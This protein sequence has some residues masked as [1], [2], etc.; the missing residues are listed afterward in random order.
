MEMKNAVAQDQP[1]S[2]TSMVSESSDGSVF[3]CLAL[4]YGNYWQQ[5]HWP[6]VTGNSA[7]LSTSQWSFAPGTEGTPAPSVD[8]WP[9]NASK[10]I[11]SY[12]VTEDGDEMW[13]FV[14]SVG[15]IGLAE[16]LFAAETVVVV[17]A[18]GLA[19]T[20]TTAV[21]AGITLSPVIIIG[22]PLTGLLILCVL[23]SSMPD[24]PKLAYYNDLA[25]QSIEAQA[26]K[27][28]RVDSSDEHSPYVSGTFANLATNA[29]IDRFARA[30]ANV[31][32]GGSS[33]GGWDGEPPVCGAYVDAN[34]VVRRVWWWI[35]TLTRDYQDIGVMIWAYVYNGMP[36]NFGGAFD[37]KYKNA[38]PKIPPDLANRGWRVK[39]Y[40]SCSEAEFEPGEF[41][42]PPR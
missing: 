4:M 42:S 3:I 7:D 40:N 22:A 39:I 1:C 16:S 21:A 26:M 9:T 15:A 35:H 17:E 14:P 13:S 31:A 11:Y 24:D 33:N 34:G 30:K 29:L 18:T 20:E 41:N 25:R 12:F 38:L 32:A 19:A 37:G 27:P 2:E 23:T 6:A 5:I 10:T 28:H 8:Y 36:G